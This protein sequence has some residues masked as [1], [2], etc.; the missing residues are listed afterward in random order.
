MK[1][2]LH[3]IL[4]VVLLINCFVAAAQSINVAGTIRGFRHNWDC[5]NDGVSA[6]CIIANYPDPR[7][8]VWVGWDGA[9]FS[10]STNNPGL[11]CGASDYTYGADSEDCSTWNPGDITLPTLTGNMTTY[12]VEMQS[13]E[14][15]GCFSNCTPNT[16]GVFDNFGNSDDTRCGRLRIGDISL[17]SY[18]P[19]TNHTFNGDFQSGSFLSMH[20]RC[21][22]NNGAG[23]GIDQLVL[24]WTFNAAPTVTFQPTDASLGG[25]PRLTCENIALSLEVRSNTKCSWTL[26]RWVR[27]EESTDNVTWTAIAGTDNSTAFTT[28]TTFAYNPVLPNAAPGSPLIRYY[29]AVLVSACAKPTTDAGWRSSSLSTISAVMQVTIYDPTDAFC[30][31]PQCNIMYVD[32]VSGNDANA[33]SPVLP[34]RTISAAAAPGVTYIRVA[35]CVSGCTDAGVV[36]IPNNCVIEGGYVRSGGSNEIWTKSSATADETNITFSG[37]ENA[38]GSNNSIRHIVAFKADAK[39][40]WTVK[41]LNITT[42]NT[43]A[44]T[45]AN[46]GRGM[47]KL[48]LFN[49]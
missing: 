11:Y 2:N 22:D 41:D 38:P 20:N 5:C 28:Q 7:Y 35:R 47:S 17:C 37:A 40:G 4:T 9:N 19:C 6:G 23:Y 33:G 8:K 10:Q 34:K 12:N 25:S 30:T 46:D 15:D 3:F 24:N 39:S 13:W 14:E 42:A 36:N 44:L 43:P 26:A 45:Y 48:W 27:W 18:A 49:N 29:R 16:C 1:K 32:P 31:A 21:G